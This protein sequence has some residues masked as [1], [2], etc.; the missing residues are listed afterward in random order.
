[1][2]NYGAS[3]EEIAVLPVVKY[4]RENIPTE[5]EEHQCRS[6]RAGQDG[7][8]ADP[9]AEQVNPLCSI[10]LADYEEGE[11]PMELPCRHYFHERCA[12]TW[13]QRQ[14]RCPL[15]Q[16]SIT[17]AALEAAAAARAADAAVAEASNDNAGDMHD[18]D[19]DHRDAVSSDHAKSSREHTEVE[20]SSHVS[21]LQS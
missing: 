11:A 2:I 19:G 12:K 4:H 9:S 5:Q 20:L 13:L 17:R 18:N 16:R 21:Q 6:A 3:D 7:S 8:G 1:L 15:C 14:N 10:C